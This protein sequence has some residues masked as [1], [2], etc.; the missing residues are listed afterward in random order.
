VSNTMTLQGFMFF[1]RAPPCFFG[2]ATRARH[3]RERAGR[4]LLG[5]WALLFKIAAEVNP[6]AN[7][8]VAQTP[9]RESAADQPC[10]SR[11]ALRSPSGCCSRS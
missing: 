5:R 9:I 3:Q 2:E 8:G 4:E 1:S 10:R 7:S 11:R 6:G